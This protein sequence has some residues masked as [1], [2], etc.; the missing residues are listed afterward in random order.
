MTLVV[1][2]ILPEHPR[3]PFACPASHRAG[4]SFDD[5]QGPVVALRE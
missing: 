2:E 3:R 4:H 1:T 5:C